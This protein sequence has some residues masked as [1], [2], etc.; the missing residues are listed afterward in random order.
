M[1]VWAVSTENILLLHV[2]KYV[3]AIVLSKDA[4]LKR[5]SKAFL[6]KLLKYLNL[7]KA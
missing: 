6:L 4:H 5:F 2:L 1:H 3:S 7:T